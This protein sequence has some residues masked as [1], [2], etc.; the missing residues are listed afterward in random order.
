M[1]RTLQQ[2]LIIAIVAIPF[3]AFNQTYATAANPIDCNGATHDL[4][5]ELDAGKIIVIG[6]TMPCA[7]CAGPLLQVH[8]E[9]LNYAISDPGIVEYWLTDDFANT[10]CSSI[11]GWCAGNGI[12][13]AIFFSSSEL[14]MYDYGSAGMPKVVV[15]GCTDH[16]VYYNENDTPTGQGA[17]NG[18]ENALDD[19]ANSCLQSTG[20][21]TSTFTELKCFPNPASSEVSLTFNT[22]PNQELL[23]EVVDL[24]GVVV[25]QE[26]VTNENSSSVEM[27]IYV[28]A[29]NDGMYFVKVSNS[30]ECAVVKI[31]IQK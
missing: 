23:I 16:R 6:W 12:T 28:Q 20:E 30:E 21:I 25:Y 18:I 15:V 9:V 13:N 26:S 31:Q 17:R 2:I 27:S 11:E 4:F 24:A 5:A 29:W 1:K 3:Q 19:L 14:N 22:D 10:S 8:N 7:T